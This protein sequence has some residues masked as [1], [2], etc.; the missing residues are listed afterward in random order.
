MGIVDLLNRRN[1]RMPLR[2]KA[3][4]YQVRHLDEKRPA[5]ATEP[6][7]DLSGERMELVQVHVVVV[8]D[9][10]RRARAWCPTGEKLGTRALVQRV[11]IDN[12]A[13]KRGLREL[14]GTAEGKDVDVECRASGIVSYQALLD[15]IELRAQFVGWLVSNAAV[16]LQ[17]VA[18]ARIKRS[19][20]S[21]QQSRRTDARVLSSV[22]KVQIEDSHPVRDLAIELHLLAVVRPNVT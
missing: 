4:P 7:D 13:R 3:L 11:V 10:E 9:I 12:R 17:H 16:Y 18:A 6:G 1:L 20:L 8:T 14:V 19:V 5:V 2:T 21:Q 15:Q 22:A